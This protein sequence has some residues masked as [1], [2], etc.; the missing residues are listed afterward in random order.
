MGEWSGLGSWLFLCRLWFG[1][2]WSS[3]AGHTKTLYEL[4]RDGRGVRGEK[5]KRRLARCYICLFFGIV[6]V[7][8]SLSSIR[9]NAGMVYTCVNI[10]DEC[11]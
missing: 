6:I 10:A 1:C 7:S 3:C 11:N 8:C 2:F 9:V 4:M 5:L